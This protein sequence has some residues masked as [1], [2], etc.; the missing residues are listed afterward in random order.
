MVVR[1]ML[2]NDFLAPPSKVKILHKVCHSCVRGNL[3]CL[4]ASKI[5]QLSYSFRGWVWTND[6]VNFS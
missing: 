1:R 2:K 5:M 6:C 3:P 4:K